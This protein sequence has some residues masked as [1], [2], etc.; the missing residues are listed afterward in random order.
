MKTTIEAIKMLISQYIDI[1]NWE[2]QFLTNG[3]L[4]F[5]E[6]DTP[7]KEWVYNCEFG[8]NSDE[9]KQ[10]A[11]RIALFKGIEIKKKTTH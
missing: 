3:D 1:S 2:F 9:A 11:E 4:E 10:I 6:K 8:I 5:H 7:H